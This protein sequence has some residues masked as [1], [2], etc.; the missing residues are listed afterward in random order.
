MKIIISLGIMFWGLAGFAQPITVSNNIGD[1]YNYKVTYQDINGNQ[2]VTEF[3]A[4]SG[5]T[6]PFVIPAVCPG[7]PTYDKIYRVRISP[8]CFFSYLAD[9]YAGLGQDLDQISHCGS[10]LTTA[11]SYY[12]PAPYNTREL[13]CKQI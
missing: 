10:C 7:Q 11:I 8:N 12:L 4:S 1:D 6:Y 9:H 5:I 13:H 3:L 2:I